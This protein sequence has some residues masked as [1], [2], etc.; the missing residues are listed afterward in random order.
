MH[1]DVQNDGRGMK[2]ISELLERHTAADASE[3]D[4]LAR[5]RGLLANAHAPFSREH[6]VPGHL[7]ASAIVLNP[8]RTRTLLILH[9]KLN[10]WLQP[11]GH[12][13]PGESDPSV[14]AAR[15]VHEETGLVSR[16]PGDKPLLLDVDVHTIP[17]RKNE[18]QH[19]H[20]DLRMLLVADGEP[21]AG[22]VSAV[23]WV[24]PGEFEAMK[25]DPGLQRALK[26]IRFA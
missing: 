2:L 9:A 4:S 24:Q 25:L 17:A 5:I 16:W 13:E 14:A 19:S 11:G 15:E 6:F 1:R 10:M 8:G 7:T 23:K 18:P 3:A 12:F 21:T 20:F 22:E 26:K